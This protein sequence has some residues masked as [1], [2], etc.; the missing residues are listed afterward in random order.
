M[1]SI[2]PD[3]LKRLVGYCRP[4]WPHLL[5]SLVLTMIFGA[6]N[7][8]VLPLVRDITNEISNRNLSHFNNQIFNA[9]G[10]FF[11]R[12]ASQYAQSYLMMMI[13]FGISRDIRTDFFSRLLAL[14]QSY[15]A[16]NKLGDVLTRLT[17]DAERVREGITSFFWELI[18]NIVS[19]IGVMGY[20]FYL[21]FR[22]TLFS[23]V[24]V[25]VFIAVIMFLANR[26]KKVAGQ[27]QTQSAGISH[28]IQ[29]VLTNIKLVQAYGA[30]R[31]EVARFRKEIQRSIRT[32][33]RGIRFRNTVEP[34][35]TYMQFLVILA[36]VWYGG[37]EIAKGNM[38]GPTLVSFFAGVFLLVDP[39]L[40][41][42]KTYT[43]F[44][45]SMVSVNR[46]FEVINLEVEIA[47]PVDSVGPVIRGEVVFENVRFG[48]HPDQLAIDGISITAKPG[49]V[50]AL[51]GLSGA[52]KSTLVNLIPRFYDVTGGRILID[53]KDVRSYKLSDLRGAIAVVPQEDMLFRGTIYENI[54]YSRPD[55]TLDQVERAA[56]DANAWEF[57]ERRP[58][59]LFTKIGDR[60]MRLSGGQRQRVSI[61][62]AVLREPKILILDE[63]TS[64][65][66][67]QSEHLVQTAL[68]RLMAGR[69]TF[70]IAHRLSTIMTADQILVIDGG[71]VIEHG[72]HEQLINLKGQYRRLVDL[73]FGTQAYD[74]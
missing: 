22:L 15:F 16:K 33:M 1:T 53:G 51:V 13:A 19:L 73:Q 62:R 5:G 20:L 12:L 43:N 34:L 39:I 45:Q 72:T 27:S 66:D 23:L 9:A 65:L 40:A 52:G 54:R 64:S 31:R 55:A 7:V 69:T 42:S 2:N 8:M 3:L 50:I 67:T 44:Q 24:A 57:I 56:R 32:S 47:D 4:Y 28:L 30:E 11:V 26:L 59:R 74:H 10:L 17:S 71:Q 21:N 58:K 37:Y 60:G 63:A 68:E 14:P 48:Y 29:E 18:P 38:S 36:V 49:Q 70:V 35:I 46:L 6:A 61:A 41:V 25:P